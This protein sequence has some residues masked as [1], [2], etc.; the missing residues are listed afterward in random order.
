MWIL[1]E[2]RDNVGEDSYIYRAKVTHVKG[3]GDIPFGEIDWT[4]YWVGLP[5]LL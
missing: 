3:I 4:I 1:R 2:E 5:Y